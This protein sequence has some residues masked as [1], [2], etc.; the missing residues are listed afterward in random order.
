MPNKDNKLF[1]RIV[2]ELDLECVRRSS[3]PQ[4][5]KLDELVEQRRKLQLESK[6]LMKA[7][8]AAKKSLQA[9]LNMAL[10]FENLV[11]RNKVDE[12]SS[13]QQSGRR[14][15]LPFI[16]CAGVCDKS[17]SGGQG[18]KISLMHDLK[19]QGNG[20]VIETMDL[21]TQLTNF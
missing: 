7:E 2:K 10:A 20:K 5:G 21:T 1:K 18:G 6:R 14:Y 13:S 11:T 15:Q 8:K 4:P 9:D 16:V 3:N 12:S 17:S 19:D